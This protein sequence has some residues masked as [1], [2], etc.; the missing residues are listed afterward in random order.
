MLKEQMTMFHL[1]GGR[2]LG[3]SVDDG[4]TLKYL[5][6]QNVQVTFFT[7]LMA[8]GETLT[9]IVDHMIPEQWFFTSATYSDAKRDFRLSSDAG[10][11]LFYPKTTVVS[12]G[13]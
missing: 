6:T 11:P 8:N 7:D 4:I 1:G 9:T 5:Q 12:S 10:K 2:L 13:S 3:S